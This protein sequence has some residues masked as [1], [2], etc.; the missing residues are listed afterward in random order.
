ME[1]AKEPLVINGKITSIEPDAS[2]GVI[3]NEYV[4][5]WDALASDYEDV[6]INDKVTAECIECEADVFRWRCLKVVLKKSA[7]VPIVLHQN[8]RT[9]NKN[10]IEIT[11]SIEVEFNKRDE[12]KE[13]T[14]MVKNTSDINHKV[15]ESHFKGRKSDSQLELISPTRHA[16]VLLKPGEEKEYRFK[17]TSKNY[18]IA[19][20]EFQ[21]NFTEPTFQICRFIKVNV[22]DTQQLHNPMGTGSNKLKNFTYSQEVWNRKSTYVLIPG[23]PPKKT[24][25]FVAHKFEPFHIPVDPVDLIKIVLDPASSRSN[26]CD[27]LDVELP[28]LKE[29]LKLENYNQKFHTLLHLEECTSFHNMRKYDLT[30]H[31]TRDNEYLQLEVQNLAESRPSIAIGE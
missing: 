30:S 16:T 3:D 23:V 15:S 26:I 28:F 9:M 17:A 29:D 19:F 4:F 22:I 24:P 5:F 11:D 6:N 20:E 7:S 13:F 31:F 12:T 18:G 2:G 25:N 1:P 8:K 27:N 14:V 10:G 21:F